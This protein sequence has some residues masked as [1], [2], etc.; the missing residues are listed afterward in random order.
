MANILKEICQGF[1]KISLNGNT[2]FF[3][4]PSVLQDDLEEIYKKKVK[5]FQEEGLWTESEALSCLN[6]TGVWTEE[7][8]KE[9]QRR[10]NKIRNDKEAI[11]KMKNPLSRRN[12]EKQVEKDLL[13]WEEQFKERYSCI[14]KTAEKAAEEFIEAE[15]VGN[16]LFEDEGFLVPLKHFDSEI[17]SEVKKIWERV[18]VGEI[19]KVCCMYEFQDLFLTGPESTKQ[20]FGKCS[21]E[22][23]KYQS[24]LFSQAKYFHG[25]FIHMNIP[26]DIEGNPEKIISFAKQKREQEN[27]QTTDKTKNQ[28]SSSGKKSLKGKDLAAIE[29]E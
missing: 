10:L 24:I 12:Q 27:R 29:T 2:A 21:I 28:L 22:L 11:S 19:R 18:S 4:H 14:S 23:T 13:I 3:K 17:M 6:E 26:P 1:S 9:Y 20:F 25:I 5:E 16:S 8:E 15:H 7:Q